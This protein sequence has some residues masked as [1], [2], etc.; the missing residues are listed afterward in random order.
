[1]TFWPLISYNDSPTDQTFHKFYDHVTDIKI[2]RI[3]SSSMEH[4]KRVWHASRE[5][6]PFQTLVYFLIVETSF[7]ELVVSFLD[8]SPCIPLDTFSISLDVWIIC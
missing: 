6:L 8:F 1:M 7:P 4:L 3:S 2:H 5:R